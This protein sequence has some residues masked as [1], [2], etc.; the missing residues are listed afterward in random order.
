RL[1]MRASSSSDSSRA[2]R[3]GF[4]FRS[5]QISSERTWPIPYRY[6]S[7]MYVGLSFGISTPWIRGML[8]DSVDFPVTHVYQRACISE[9]LFRHVR[10]VPPRHFAD[11]QPCRCLCRGLVE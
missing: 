5:K 6:C 4:S 9:F 1:V 7:E 8:V 10:N 2:L 11:D 3:W